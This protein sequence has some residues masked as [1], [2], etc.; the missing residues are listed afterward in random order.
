MIRIEIAETL[1]KVYGRHIP[2]AWGQNSPDTSSVWFDG[3]MMGHSGVILVIPS[4]ILI[5]AIM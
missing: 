5:M 3:Q 2:L 4:I 1:Q